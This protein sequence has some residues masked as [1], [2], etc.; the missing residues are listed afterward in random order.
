[1]T[2]THDPNPYADLDCSDEILALYVDR[3]NAAILKEL[4]LAYPAGDRPQFA[5]LKAAWPKIEAHVDALRYSYSVS[6]DFYG[7]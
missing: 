7:G 1:M 4:R 6:I 3:V 5:L 2:N